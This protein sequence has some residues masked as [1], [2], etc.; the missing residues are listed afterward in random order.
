MKSGRA[1]VDTEIIDLSVL[2]ATGL[3]GIHAY[4][5]ITERGD[6]NKTY[7]VGSW[8]EYVNSLGGLIPESIFPLICKRALERGAKLRVGRMAHFTTISDPTTLVG[9]KAGGTNNTTVLLEAANIGAWGNGLSVAITAAVNGATDEFDIAVSLAGY[10]D[11]TKTVIRNIPKVLTTATIAEF[12]T[13]SEL[14]KIKVASATQSLIAGTVVFTLGAETKANIVLADFTGSAIAK[15]GMHIFDDYSDFVRISLPEMAVPE[16]DI[17][18][19]AYVEQRKDCRAI[20]RTPIGISGNVAID[21]REGTGTYSHTPIDNWRASMVFGGVDVMNERTSARE[22]IPV[23]GDVTGCYSSKDNVAFEWFSAAGP[24]RGRI[25]NAF[26]IDYNLGSPA[27]ATEADS[28]DV[29]GINPVIDD[30]D[31]GLVYWGNSTLTKANKM[32]KHDNI[33]ELLIYITRTVAPLCKSEL[34]D[35]NDVET[36]KAIYRNVNPLMRLLVDKRALWDYIY[37][38]D[39]NIDKISDAKVNRPEDVDNGEYVFILWIKP[40]AALKYVGVKVV[41]TN[42]GINFEE[43]TSQPII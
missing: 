36:W 2:V 17:A 23:I 16:L 43:I 12:N 14:V 42:S 39:Q 19:V 7:L 22:I 20:L 32:T 34:F 37:D 31:Y 33:A 13:L 27:R 4:G 10:P 21:Y 35:P 15:N 29:H 28:V 38:G 5:G 25:G 18:L 3:K 30:K 41:V 40:K 9:V 8:Q 11:L 26:G 1:R 24:K 6:L